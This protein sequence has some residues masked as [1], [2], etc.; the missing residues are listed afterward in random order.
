MDLFPSESLKKCETIGRGAGHLVGTKVQRLKI[1]CSIK[2]LDFT[3]DVLDL[4]PKS[5]HT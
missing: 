5:F 2:I 4:K 1:A 3:K